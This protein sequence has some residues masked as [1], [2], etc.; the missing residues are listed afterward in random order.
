MYNSSNKNISSPWDTFLIAKKLFELKRESCKGNKK[1]KVNR[2]RDVIAGFYLRVHTSFYFHCRSS[3]NQTK[4]IGKHKTIMKNIMKQ[5][6]SEQEGVSG[7][8]LVDFWIKSYCYCARHNGG[9]SPGRVVRNR[10][11]I[12]NIIRQI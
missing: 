9:H 6:G 11:K 10:I 7:Q 3:M 4:Y 5:Q 2:H 8:C 12:L 1:F